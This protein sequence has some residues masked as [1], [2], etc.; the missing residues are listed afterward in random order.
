MQ[1][2]KVSENRIFTPE[3]YFERSR[4]FPEIFE[5]FVLE[6]LKLRVFEVWN[7]SR[8]G[9]KFVPKFQYNDDLN[10]F[11]NIGVKGKVPGATILKKYHKMNERLCD[12]PVKLKVRKYVFTS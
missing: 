12:E 2:T 4:L 9:P 5:F 6:N 8:T 1:N 3:N 10:F 7:L 11:L